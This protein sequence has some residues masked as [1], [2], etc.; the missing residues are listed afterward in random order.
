[1]P[2]KIKTAVHGTEDQIKAKVKVCTTVGHTKLM[3]LA[4]RN[5]VPEINRKRRG[6]LAWARSR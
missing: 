5:F 2:G 6:I 3:I 1:M 4:G